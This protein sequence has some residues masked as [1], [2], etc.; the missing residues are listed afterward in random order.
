MG[1]C[2][3]REDSGWF[4]R[5]EKGFGSCAR[6]GRGDQYA[7]ASVLRY[8]K[9]LRGIGGMWTYCSFSWQPRR[10]SEAPLLARNLRER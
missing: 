2:G 5:L 3:M 10:L 9:A 4:S 8:E 6:D 7:A 1:T